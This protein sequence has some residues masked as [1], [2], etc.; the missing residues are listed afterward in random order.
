MRRSLE[1]LSQFGCLLQVRHFRP[2]L[3][4]GYGDLGLLVSTLLSLSCSTIAS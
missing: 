3:T 2:L 4:P 1:V